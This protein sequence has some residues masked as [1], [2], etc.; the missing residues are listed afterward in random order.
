VPAG[1]QRKR[2]LAAAA[3]KQPQAGWL[4]RVLQM[5]SGRAARSRSVWVWT[6]SVAVVV[7]AAVALSL[8]LTASKKPV[9][10]GGRYL[11]FTSCLLTDSHGLSGEPAAAAWA[12]LQQAANATRMQA[13]YL[14][15][16]ASAT[17]AAPYLASLVVRHCGVVVAAGPVEAAAVRAEAR[18][19]S[20]VRFVVI[21]GAP[22]GA[23]VVVVKGS[24]ARIP[25]QVD[26]QVTRALQ[27]SG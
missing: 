22:A 26:A 19:Y 6:A 15:V 13:Q 7:A 27:A 12:G 16:P 21:G 11:A 20:D 9:V 3:R 23:N 18:R 17:D 25:A 10:D 2:V 4:S 24:A 14:E 5:G 8:Y 1:G